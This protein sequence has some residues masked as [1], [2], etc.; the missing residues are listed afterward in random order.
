MYIC[1]Q[2]IVR[3]SVIGV[4]YIGGVMKKKSSVKIKA[5]KAQCKLCKDVIES[6]TR[7][8]FISCKCD[9]IFVDGGTSY[10]RRGAKDFKNFIDLVEYEEE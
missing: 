4:H 8:G 5:N 3:Q 10:L 2:F 7:H 9:E 6:V 1:I